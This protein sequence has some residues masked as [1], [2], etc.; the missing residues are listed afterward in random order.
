MK[1]HGTN[2]LF[3]N[4]ETSDR[5]YNTMRKSERSVETSVFLLTT[6]KGSNLP[7]PLL[8]KKTIAD[9]SPVKRI[10]WEKKAYWSVA[11]HFLPRV[12]S[13]INTDVVSAKNVRVI[14]GLQRYV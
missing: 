13:R 11:R 14:N 1:E 5:F 9:I 2:K 3:H 6:F 8:W 7:Y 4:L 10:W 12:K